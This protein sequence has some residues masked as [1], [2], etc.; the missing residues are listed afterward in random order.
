MPILLNVRK[1]GA[2]AEAKILSFSVNNYVN[3]YLPANFTVK[4]ENTGNIHVKPHGNIFISGTGGKNLAVLDIN[5]T[6]GNV[7]P[8]SSRIFNASWDDGFLVKE[9]VFE[10][11]QPK[12]DKNGKQLEKIII[13]WNKLTE[14]RIG[15]YTA[16]LLL[17][18]DNGQKDVPLEATI[19]FWIMPYKV[20][21]GIVITLLILF[22]VVKWL[23]KTYINRELKKRL[24]T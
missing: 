6:L 24:K 2:K 1:A 9:P 13:N 21:G 18:F 20:I 12:V 8:N 16:N 5:P 4:V 17:V 19:S 14:F 22:F 10:A 7:I 3:E 11:G 15:K 23:I